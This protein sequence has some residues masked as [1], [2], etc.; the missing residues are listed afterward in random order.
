MDVFTVLR[1]DHQTVSSLFKKIEALVGES[2]STKRR[3]MFQQLKAE[4]DLHAKVEDLHVYR[5]FQQAEPT[6]DG[7]A[8]ALEA[9]RKIKTVLDELAASTTYDFRWIS[10]L[11]ELRQVVEQHVAAEEQDLFTKA[12]EVLT[13][14]EAEELGVTVEAAKKD[15]QRDASPQCG[16]TPE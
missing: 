11:R 12:R 16:G 4:L 9:H 13:P 7:A 6:R 3:E 8:Q 5:V 2:D 10:K 1:Q 15:I 14:Q